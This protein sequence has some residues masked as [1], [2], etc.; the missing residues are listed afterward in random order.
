[1]LRAGGSLTEVGQ[2]LR[3]RHALTTAIYAKTDVE[4]L[5]ALVRPWPVG[6]P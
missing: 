3:H 6:A 5:R 2:V 1:M 4:G